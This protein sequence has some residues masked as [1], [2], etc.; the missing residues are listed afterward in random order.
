MPYGHTDAAN[1]PNV[2]PLALTLA[3]VVLDGLPSQPAKIIRH[4]AE[5]FD[6]LGIAEF[7]RRRITGAAERDG[8][9]VALFAR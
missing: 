5:C 9:D 4:L 2:L 3:G 8:A 1:V 6:H 7:P